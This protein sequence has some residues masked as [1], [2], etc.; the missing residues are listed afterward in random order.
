[1]HQN[2]F[3]Q[4]KSIPSILRLLED[5]EEE[6]IEPPQNKPILKKREI[7]QESDPILNVNYG[8]FDPAIQI[9]RGN[10]LYLKRNYIER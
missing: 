7:I 3:Q 9:G 8:E 4:F 5:E 2:D 10:K 6:K 1:M